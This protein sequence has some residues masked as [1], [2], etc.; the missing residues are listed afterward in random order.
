MNANFQALQSEA[1]IITIRVVVATSRGTLLNQC[2]IRHCLV[3]NKTITVSKCIV[4]KSKSICGTVSINKPFDVG[5]YFIACQCK[6]VQSFV[7][8]V[9][10]FFFNAFRHSCANNPSLEIFHVESRSVQLSSSLPPNMNANGLENGK[11]QSLS[12]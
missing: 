8:I 1:Q 3:D 12:S 9:N 6:L 4:S 5:S 11:M 7:C 10:H 2:I